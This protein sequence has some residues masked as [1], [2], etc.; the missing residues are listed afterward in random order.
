MS[1]QSLV[2]VTAKD[3]RWDYYRGS[4]HGGQKKQKTESAVRCTHLASG[5]VACS[6]DE[7]SQFKNKQIAFKRMSETKIFKNWLKA[8][9]QKALGKYK[10]VELTVNRQ[11]KSKNLKVEYKD[12]AGLWKEM[13]NEDE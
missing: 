6:E 9:T 8:Q 7:R 11:M 5:A 4:G 12:E 1:K 3:C 13:K 2:S 10:D